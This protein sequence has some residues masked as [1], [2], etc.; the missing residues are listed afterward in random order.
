V[1][2]V[3]SALDA[4]AQYLRSNTTTFKFA[5][6][7]CEVINEWCVAMRSS[8]DGYLRIAWIYA[9]HETIDA[10]PGEVQLLSNSSTTCRNAP[11]SNKW[12]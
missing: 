5:N 11:S 9:T 12:N 10:T 4:C 2:D 8:G 3:T 6:A 1:I 7:T